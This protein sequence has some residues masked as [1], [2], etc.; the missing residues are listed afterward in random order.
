MQRGIRFMLLLA[1][2]ASFALLLGDG[3]PG[4]F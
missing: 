4:P 3:P 1:V 2:A